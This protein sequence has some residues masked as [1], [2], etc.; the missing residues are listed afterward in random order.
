MFRGPEASG[1]A[2]RRVGRG[3]R[4]TPRS[5]WRA[6]GWRARRLRKEEG[7]AIHDRAFGDHVAAQV[8]TDF[9]SRPRVASQAAGTLDR[10]A[11]VQH[12]PV[13]PA[14]AGRGGRTVLWTA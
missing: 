4:R 2:G 10:P 13:G 12:S 8:A 14:A 1:T 11:P 5:A 9:L 3:G 6:G 7:E